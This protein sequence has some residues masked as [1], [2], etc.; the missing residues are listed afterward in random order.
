MADIPRKSS[1]ISPTSFNDYNSQLQIAVLKATKNAAAL[2]ADTAFY[3]SLDKELSQELDASS[4]RVL[5]LTNK[6]LRLV[7]TADSGAARGRKRARL[8]SVEDVQDRFR[9]LVVDSLDLLLER[10]DTRLDE[11]RGLL[12]PPAIAVTPGLNQ[13]QKSTKHPV[14]PGRLDPALQNA[15]HLLKPQRLFKRTV[16]NSNYSTWQPSLKHKYNA[17]V[18][19]GYRMT[20]ADAE[21]GMVISSHPYQ[22]EINHISYPPS[23]FRYTEPIPPKPFEETPFVWV[24]TPKAF[25]SLLDKLRTVSEIAIDLEHHSYRTYSGF[26]CLMQIST[27]E[28]DYIV[29][30]LALREELEELN[31]VFT[32]PKIVKVL[33]GAESDIVWLQQDFNLYIV[34]LFDTYHASKVL[35]FPRHSLATLLEMYCDFTP[36]KRYQLADWRIRPLPQEMLDYARSDTHYLLYIYDN[37]RNALLDRSGSRSNTPPDASPSDALPHA[38]LL[39][40]VLSR[41]RD[42]SL[43]VY[44]KEVYDAEGGSGLAGWD[45]LAKKWNKAFLSPT[46]AEGTQRLEVYKALHSWRDR[47]ARLE[48]ESTRYVLPNHSLFSLAEKPP[49]DIAALYNAFS[50]SVPPVIRSRGT[51]L[52]DTIRDTIRRLST[53]PAEEEKVEE[54]EI[55]GEKELGVVTS[56]DT[57]DVST[58]PTTV[59]NPR[60]NIFA[61]IF[62]HDDPM[63]AQFSALFGSASNVDRS[64]K[65]SGVFSTTRSSL[66]VSPAGSKSKRNPFAFRDILFRIHNELTVAPSI[67]KPP[68]PQPETTLEEVLMEG[69]AQATTTTNIPGQIELAYIPPEQRQAATATT[70]VVD[71][72]IVVVGQKKRKRAKH[73]PLQNLADLPEPKTSIMAVDSTPDVQVVADGDADAEDGA[74]TGVNTA[75]D[76]A[77]FDFE[78]SGSNILDDGSDHEAESASRG[79]KKRK[80]GSGLFEYGNFKAAPKAHSQLQKGNFSRTLK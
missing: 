55:D 74:A 40:E 28:C 10:T 45:Q 26:L 9:S 79:K 33:H 76:A 72:T 35:A 49:S 8:E 57:A 68:P 58:L 70:P 64:T 52:L 20:D 22:Y 61:P 15:S 75:L 12:K 14:I 21:E 53:A 67:P 50:S 37:L 56:L 30:T 73:K 42:T 43:R 32:D 60:A 34:N 29:D 44:E 5:S 46:D 27:R 48:D 69:Q 16:D 77:P 25:S 65:A 66:F 4:S 39:R 1:V 17:Q 71:D 80:G 2:P 59:K 47:V 51:E 6:L 54:I 36:D 13:P 31:E 11:V 19:L 23:L 41:S 18:P 7:E 24:D 3:A 63:S 38:T 62:D 78:A